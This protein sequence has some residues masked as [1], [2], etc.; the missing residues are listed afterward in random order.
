MSKSIKTI[1]IY[2]HN[3][4][5]ERELRTELKAGKEGVKNGTAIVFARCERRNIIK[6][7]FLVLASHLYHSMSY[8]VSA[9]AQL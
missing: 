1:N 2:S 9:T 5:R 8:S 3:R 7:I 4:E 6:I